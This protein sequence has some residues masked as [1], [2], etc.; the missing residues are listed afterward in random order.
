MI[1]PLKPVAVDVAVMYSER[2]LKQHHRNFLLYRR[3][4]RALSDHCDRDTLCR[5][6]R[7]V[8]AEF[9]ENKNETNPEQLD[10]LVDRAYFWLAKLR[11]GEPYKNIE[12]PGGTSYLRNP[13]LHPEIIKN[14]SKLT[15]HPEL[16]YRQE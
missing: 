16:F 8:R 5:E 2:F 11:N 4:L 15:E 10:F 6:A 12:Y 9:E 1:V 7:R 13:H 3:T 14:H